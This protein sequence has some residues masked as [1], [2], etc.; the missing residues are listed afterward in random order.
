MHKELNARTLQGQVALVTGGASGIGRA[1][2]LELASAGAD[3]AVVDRR[4][5]GAEVA[6]KEAQRTGADARAFVLDLGDSARIRS[7]VTDILGMFGRIDILVNSAGI[8]GGRHSALEFSDE[9]FDV[10]M[11]VNVKAPFVLTREVGRHMVERG[12]GG[13]SST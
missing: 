4:S 11:G 1:T 2:V 5:D 9:V 12:A 3:I 6:A 7:A 10:V 13:G 8:N